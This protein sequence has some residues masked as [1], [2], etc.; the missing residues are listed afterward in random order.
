ME[1]V[2]SG[3][4]HVATGICQVDEYDSNAYVYHQKF[5][6]APNKMT[7]W[8]RLV[9]QEVPVEAYSDILTVA[10]SSVFPAAVVDL[11]D[12]D[13]DAVAGGPVSASQTARRLTSVVNGPQTAKATQPA[14]DM[15]IPLTQLHQTIGGK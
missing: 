14:L 11:E 1:V 9:G 3:Y 2:L 10:G 7:G 4:A 15:W 12:V 5:R 6:I 8:K 13:G